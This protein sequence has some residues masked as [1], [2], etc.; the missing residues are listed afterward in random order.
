MSSAFECTDEIKI[1]NPKARLKQ[2]AKVYAKLFLLMGC[3]KNRSVTAST[4]P[5]IV[6]QQPGKRR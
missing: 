4:P 2:P 1:N 5:A 3:L 6:T